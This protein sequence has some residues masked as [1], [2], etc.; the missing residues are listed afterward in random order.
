VVGGFS[1]FFLGVVCFFF[2]FFGFVFVWVVCGWGGVDVL[3]WLFFF[4]LLLGWEG[5]APFV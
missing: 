1:F 2:W 4:F 5:L 3:G